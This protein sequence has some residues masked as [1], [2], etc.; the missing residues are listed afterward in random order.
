MAT[1]RVTLPT[2]SSVTF[3]ATAPAA[4]MRGDGSRRRGE[5]WIPAAGLRLFMGSEDVKEDH[6]NIRHLAEE[7][8]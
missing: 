6:V 1:H 2:L 7:E 4:M 5:G 8:A 3:D